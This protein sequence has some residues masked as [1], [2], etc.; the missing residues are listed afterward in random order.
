M[1]CLRL[2]LLEFIEI[3]TQLVLWSCGISFILNIYVCMAPTNFVWFISLGYKQIV[4]LNFSCSEVFTLL[5]LR[6]WQSHVENVLSKVDLRLI[7]LFIISLCIFNWW[8]LT[9]RWFWCQIGHL[10]SRLWK[11]GVYA[12]W[13]PLLFSCLLNLPEL[14]LRVRSGSSFKSIFSYRWLPSWIILIIACPETLSKD[15]YTCWF[16][17]RH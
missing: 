3:Q 7:Y 5:V 11:L 9:W 17:R 1:P 16:F 4:I 8:L 15:W 14:P 2:H 6:R 10:G 12:S 13:Q